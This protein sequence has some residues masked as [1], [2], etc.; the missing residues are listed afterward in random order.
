M[1]IH[2][3]QQGSDE[4]KRLRLG[5]ITGTRIKDALGANNLKLVD[6]LI[7][8]TVSDEIEEDA[9]LSASV[10]RGKEYEP[11]AIKAYEEVRG[12]RVKRI[13]F[14]TSKQRPWLGLS[15]D[16]CIVEER[17]GLEIK[18][19]DTDTHVRY[20]RMNQL[21]NE[22]KYQAFAAFL[23]CPHMEELDF[24]SYDN[25]FSIKPIWI[26]TVRRKDIQAEL[27][28]TLIALDKFYAKF[29]DYYQQVTF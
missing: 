8:E 10:Q 25:R 19:P 2:D 12:C 4:W 21:P 11:I 15:P 22:H 9:Y 26:H 7:A 3:V 16:G 13:G 27:D 29:Q 18:C 5:K 6:E 28:T 14:V 20:I 24:V 1:T 17:R 23:V